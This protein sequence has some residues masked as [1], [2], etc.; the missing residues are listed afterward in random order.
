MQLGANIT[1]MFMTD[2][3]DLFIEFRKLK[4]TG[5]MCTSLGWI[6]GI[7]KVSY[8]YHYLFIIMYL[9]RDLVSLVRG[10]VFPAAYHQRARALLNL[11]PQA[12]VNT[13]FLCQNMKQI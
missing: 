4:S 6:K 12:Q 5:I 9:R 7:I 10:F 3:I 13:S 8:F 11:P 1:D 2:I